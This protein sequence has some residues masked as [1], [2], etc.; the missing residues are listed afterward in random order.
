MIDEILSPV[1]EPVRSASYAYHFT[2]LDSLSTAP[3]KAYRNIL[4]ALQ[5]IGIVKKR[6]DPRNLIIKTFFDTKYQEIAS[7]FLAYPDPDIFALLSSID[8]AHL[9]TYEEYRAKRN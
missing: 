3:D 6:A 8:P 1:Y 9:K 2:G 7:T 5:T 4:Q